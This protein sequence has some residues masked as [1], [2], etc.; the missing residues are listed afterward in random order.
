MYQSLYDLMKSQW[1]YGI[2]SI[3]IDSALLSFLVCEE[4]LLFV[5]HGFDWKCAV[6]LDFYI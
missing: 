2:K 6:P 3:V 5:A 1:E 4:V